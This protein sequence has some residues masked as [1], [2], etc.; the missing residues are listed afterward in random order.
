MQSLRCI[1]VMVRAALLWPAA[2][3]TDKPMAV[4]FYA[5]WCMNCKMLAP[6]LAQLQPD[7]E[8]RIDFVKLD[9]TD[10]ERKKATRE[11]ARTLDILPLYMDNKAT[12]WIALLDAR[13]RQVGELR[14]FMSVEEMRAALAALAGEAPAAAD[15]KEPAQQ[16]APAPVPD[17]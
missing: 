12:G 6:K 5:D 2:A 9:V 14:H 3:A 11:Q 15:T 16:A 4:W 7:F 13:G 1:L 8:S 10:A 17:S